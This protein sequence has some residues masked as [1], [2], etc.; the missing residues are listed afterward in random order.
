MRYEEAPDN[1]ANDWIEREKH[2]GGIRGFTEEF[3][4][5]VN[6]QFSIPPALFRTHEMKGWRM[7]FKQ[8]TSHSRM[9]VHFHNKMNFGFRLRLAPKVYNN[10]HDIF[11]NMG[12]RRINEYTLEPYMF[13]S[14][15]KAITN[16]APATKTVKKV[17]YKDHYVIRESETS[18][19]SAMEN[20]RNRILDV[21]GDYRGVKNNNE[22]DYSNVI[23]LDEYLKDTA[24]IQSTEEVY[25]DLLQSL[26]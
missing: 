11:D 21:I 6:F 23:Q 3:C 4:R 13:I 22:F 25:G 9:Y 8:K 1:T 24:E 14:S 7:E 2:H 17:V 12:Q 20:E 26:G 15:E 5:Y 16:L 10:I 18:F 19:E